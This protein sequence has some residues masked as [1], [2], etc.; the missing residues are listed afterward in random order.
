MIN[1]YSST[2]KKMSKVT[3]IE[4]GYFGLAHMIKEEILHIF[5]NHISNITIRT[6]L[7][8]QKRNSFRK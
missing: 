7:P 6:E 1:E 4:R 2:S 8:K 3:P 5:L